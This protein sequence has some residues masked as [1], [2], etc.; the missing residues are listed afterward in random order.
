MSDN[1]AP[2][3]RRKLTTLEQVIC[4]WPLALVVVGGAIGGACGGAAWA[5]NTRIMSSNMSAAARY[6]LVVVSGIGAGILY[7]GLV[8][9]LALMFPNLFAPQ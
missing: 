2:N 6:S 8:S 7:V 5:L 9:V 1:V 3:A 4:A